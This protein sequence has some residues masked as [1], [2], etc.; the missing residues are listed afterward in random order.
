MD[1]VGGVR[2]SQA[3]AA[4]PLPVTDMNAIA[5][6]GDVVEGLEFFGPFPSEQV[7]IEWCEE[8]FDRLTQWCVAP[9]NEPD[10]RH[11]QVT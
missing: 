4:H 8:H 6:V 11:V 9:M 2:A 5:I 1:R 7:A 10:L 3:C